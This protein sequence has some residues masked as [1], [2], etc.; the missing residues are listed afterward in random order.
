MFE[1]RMI[2]GL[3]RNIFHTRKISVISIGTSCV[4]NKEMII[5]EIPLDILLFFF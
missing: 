1:M 2:D 3:T 5:K 4:I